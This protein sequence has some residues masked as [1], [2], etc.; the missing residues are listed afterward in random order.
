MSLSYATDRPVVPARRESSAASAW[1]LLSV[2]VGTYLAFGLLT[3]F[4]PLLPWW[5]VLPAGAYVVCLHGSLQH[6]A[7]HGHPFPRRWM[8]SLLVFPS[9]WLWLPYPV[10]RTAHLRHHRDD[11]LTEPLEDPESYYVTPE[12]W[13]RMGRLHRGLRLWMNTLAGR[14]L[15]WPAY[16]VGWVIQDAVR[17]AARGE[18]ATL[19]AWAAHLPA[20][21]VVVVWVVW[22]CGIPF[23]A[24]L[25]LFAYPGLSL[26]LLR[27][28]AEHRAAAAVGHR[29]A[30]IESGP[31]LSLLYLNNNLHAL[32]HAEP[33]VAWHRRP[34]RYRA[35]RAELLA[36]NDGYLF[37]GYREIVRR[38]LL[39]R[40]EPIVHPQR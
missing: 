17:R 39:S 14:L 32:H 34:A 13:Q 15:L 27:S 8:N 25:L 3:W 22:V 1:P 7:A 23:W 10:Y 33:G 35:R 11:H 26:T 24:Y 20:V 28:F 36:G 4:Y 30:V 6:E 21:A 19:R 18:P 31:L 29:T 5:L 38:F 12:R 16:V 37:H 9:L 2:A 40:R